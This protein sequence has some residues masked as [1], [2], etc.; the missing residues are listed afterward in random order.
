MQRWSLILTAYHYEIVYR[1]SAEHA[2]ADALLRLVSSSAD[3][4]LD[5]D[6]Y[7]I[8]YV[9]KLPITARGSVCNKQ[10]SSFS[11]RV[12]FHIT[13]MA[14]S[15]CRSCVTAVFFTQA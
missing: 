10:R 5:V 4:K 2:N 8:R 6:E 3:D 9:N 7:F 13:R 11:S 12:R 14:F 1:R 15:T